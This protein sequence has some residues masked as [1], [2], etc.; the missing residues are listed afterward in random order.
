MDLMEM[1]VANVA[2]AQTNVGKVKETVIM[3]IIVLVI[4]SVDQEMDLVIIVTPHVTLMM[5]L[6]VA[7]I[8]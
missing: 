3:T 2:Q 7:R 8:L 6:I 4:W 1:V 5:A